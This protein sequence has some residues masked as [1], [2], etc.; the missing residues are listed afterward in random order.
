MAFNLQE[1]QQ[2]KPCQ[3]SQSNQHLQVCGCLERYGVKTR[4][5]FL[6]IDLVHLVDLLLRSNRTAICVSWKAPIEK[7][8]LVDMEKE[9]V[10]NLDPMRSPENTPYVPLP[11]SPNQHKSR[12]AS[13]CRSAGLSDPPFLRITRTGRA[14][15]STHL[16]R[17]SEIHVIVGP[18]R[19]TC[20]SSDDVL[21]P[22][23]LLED[24][25]SRS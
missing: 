22:C 3:S 4:G 25:V 8:K 20:G 19:E 11:S 9:G 1:H 6:H 7:L 21:T 15:R 17:G 18:N 24:F 14:Q 2:S 5:K 23:T 12:V 13:T 10:A 16:G